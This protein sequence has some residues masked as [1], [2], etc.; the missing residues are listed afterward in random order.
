MTNLINIKS[1]AD[2][3]RLEIVGEIWEGMARDVGL[4]IKGPVSAMSETMGGPCRVVVDIHSPGGSVM[5]GWRIHNQ[6][7]ALRAAGHRVDVEVNALAASMASVIAMAGETITI[8]SNG[9]MM[10]HDPWGFSVGTADDLR[11]SADLFDRLAAQICD[12]YSA[13]TGIDPEEIRKMM[14]EETW[15]DGEDA[16]G[17]GFATD[18]LPAVAAAALSVDPA[19][20][21]KWRHNPIGQA[22]EPPPD[23]DEEAQEES[24]A[25]EA[26]TPTATETEE[27]ADDP[28]VTVDPPPEPELPLST[29][30]SESDGEAQDPVTPQ[31]GWIQRMKAAL[32]GNNELTAR[33]SRAEARAAELESEI[34][35]LRERVADRDHMAGELALIQEAFAKLELEAK[36]DARKRSDFLMAIGKGHPAADDLPAPAEAAPNVRDQ[37]LAMPAGEARARFYSA[38]KAAIEALA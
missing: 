15:M 5:D 27:T 6:L 33:C 9:W 16:V 19:A 12:A 24:E 29:T 23:D 3:V 34:A 13:R 4:A 28:T 37:W 11:K 36:Q 26:E 1:A 31:A 18:L 14:A 35:A 25:V 17:R 2:H 10:I 7:I 22:V 20:T 38:H 32:G 30:D 21:A 8:P